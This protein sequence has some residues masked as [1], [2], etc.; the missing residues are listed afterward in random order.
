MCAQQKYSSFE[1]TFYVLWEIV[2]V[3]SIYKSPHA[4]IYVRTYIRIYCIYVHMYK[5]TA[6]ATPWKSV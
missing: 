2:V 6:S 1:C 4:H 3:Q 5:F